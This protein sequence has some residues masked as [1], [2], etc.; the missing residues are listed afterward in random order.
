M[1]IRTAAIALAASLATVAFAED[2][3]TTKPAAAIHET[4][5][6]SAGA[7]PDAANWSLAKT[8]GNSTAKLDGNGA[9]VLNTV[10]KNPSHRTLLLSKSS[11]IDPFAA[12]VKIELTGLA[13]A[14][15][16][17]ADEQY[18]SAY[19]LLGRAGGPEEH[20]YYPD[21]GEM[22]CGVSVQVRKDKAG[23]FDVRVD[24]LGTDAPHVFPLAAAPSGLT[25]TIDG[26]KKTLEVAVAGT[27]FGELKS[28]TASITLGD[29]FTK[30]NLSA[31]G[32]LS[33]R[34]AIG[35]LNGG[36]TKAGTQVTI[37]GV[38]VK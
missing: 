18:V 22:A 27:E 17:T 8:A 31:D 29:G 28:S 5:E 6:G 20:R 10:V 16:P 23:K 7:K 14:G 1:R 36:A 13:L 26:A 9:I 34:V 11:A 12:P 2:V 3:A 25:V 4:F 33:S 32:K 37:G 21:A 38:E 19:V 35:A 15:E 30:E 24:E